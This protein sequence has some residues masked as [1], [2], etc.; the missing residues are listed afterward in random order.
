M[1]VRLNVMMNVTVNTTT[2]MFGINV[3]NAAKDE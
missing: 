1:N 3:V 2:G